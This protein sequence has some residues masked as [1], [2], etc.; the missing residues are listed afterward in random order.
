M[1]R[2]RKGVEEQATLR[3]AATFAAACQPRATRSAQ[4]GIT[5]SSLRLR[6]LVET[7]SKCIEADDW[8]DKNPNLLVGLFCWAHE[9]V[10]GVCPID[11]VRK[12]YV[13]A[14]QGAKRLCEELGGFD[15]ALRFMR[16][17]WAREG[18]RE[19]WRRQNKTPGRVL[20]WRAV[21][22]QR[23]LLTEM[24]IAEARVGGVQ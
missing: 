19:E 1:A 15:E 10:Y 23:A 18:D 20:T 5:A 21:F 3:A 8:G 14:V 13:P 11:D 4:K 16:W 6:L 7:V 17:L 22:V 2:V 24:R 9:Q 12:F